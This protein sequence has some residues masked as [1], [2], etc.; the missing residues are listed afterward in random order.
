M[1]RQ[2]IE[3]IEELVNAREGNKLEQVEIKKN[4]LL[5]IWW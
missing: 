5:Q 4:E 3:K 1:I 2:A